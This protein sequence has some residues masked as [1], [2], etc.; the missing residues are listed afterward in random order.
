MAAVQGLDAQQCH[1]AYVDVFDTTHPADVLHFP[2]DVFAAFIE[3]AKAG[4]Y[5]DLC[6][7]AVELPGGW[8]VAPD[9]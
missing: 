4:K 6:P 7:T 8:P 2:A 9:L 3:R 1:R 5:D